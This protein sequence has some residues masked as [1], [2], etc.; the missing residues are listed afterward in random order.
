M[1]EKEFCYWLKGFFELSDAK[2][3]DS[4]QIAMIKEHLDLIFQ[5]DT[6]TLEDLRSAVTDSK[7][8]VKYNIRPTDNHT[9]IC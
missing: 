9:L 3:L 2:E 1:T 7:L 8:T 6:A 4:A 5:K